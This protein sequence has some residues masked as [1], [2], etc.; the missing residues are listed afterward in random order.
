MRFLSFLLIGLLFVGCKSKTSK[1]C[2]TSSEEKSSYEVYKLSE[3][4]ALMERMFNDNKQ[5]KVKIE[6]GET[7]LGKFDADY[8]KIHT[9][10]LTDPSDMDDVFKEYADKFLIA[11]KFVYS[12]SSNQ[13]ENFNAM[14]DACIACHQKKCGGPIVRIKKLYLK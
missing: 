10:L 7:D 5:I 8:L 6:N 11:Q 9:A 1:E 2:S 13:K 3:M 4:A 14:V 12:E